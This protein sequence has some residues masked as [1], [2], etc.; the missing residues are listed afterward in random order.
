MIAAASPGIGLELHLSENEGNES[1]L[2][3]N[4]VYSHQN[5]PEANVTSLHMYELLSKALA[6]IGS[7]SELKQLSKFGLIG[8]LNTILGYS[9]FVIFL[10]WFNYF[11]ALI[12]SHIIAVTHSY[13]WNKFWTFN[14]NRKPLME[15]VKFNSVYLVVFAVNAIALFLL[16]DVFN[17][18]PRVGQLFMLPIVTIISFTGHKC[19]SF[20]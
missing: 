4:Y 19:W 12:F 8:V 11:W 10:N 15:F 18:D 17:F 7:A 16:V 20:K 1:L 6:K 5:G 2:N 14:S 13:L 3:R 9:L